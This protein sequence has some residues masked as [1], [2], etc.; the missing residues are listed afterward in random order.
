[1]EED[2]KDAERHHVAHAEVPEAEEGLA[3]GVAVGKLVAECL[4]G[5]QPTDHDTSEEGSRWQQHLRGKEVAEFHQRHSEK[6][7]ARN[8]SNG[9]GAAYG[10]KTADKGNDPRGLPAVHVQLFME[11]SGTYL[12]HGDGAG[13]GGKYKKGIEEDS[14]NV[15]RN[16]KL[17]K[18]LLEHV[19]QGD[20]D[21]RWPAVGIAY[22]ERC[23][24]DHQTGKN[25]N[26]GVQ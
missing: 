3:D 2:E 16:G 15:A 11:E 22:G 18:G 9:Q 21:E 20:E 25:G 14:D 6:L 1:M 12:M 4:T 5:N 24:E 10:N 19:G 26:D 13:Q 17:G 7:Y 23:G 8:G